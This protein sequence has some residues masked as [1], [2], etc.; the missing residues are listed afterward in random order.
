M[1]S[2]AHLE[3]N[4]LNIYPKEKK[5]CFE[6]K[7]QRK[8][9]HM[10]YVHWNLSASLTV[11]EIIKRDSVLCH[12]TIKQNG[13]YAMSCKTYEPLADLSF[14]NENLEAITERMRQNCYAMRTVTKLFT[15]S[16][17]F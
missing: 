12:V 2:C 4:S 6:R 11:F 1:P 7:L 9:R 15:F 10:L 16:R 3:R 17:R 5:E 14:T 8:I 13:L